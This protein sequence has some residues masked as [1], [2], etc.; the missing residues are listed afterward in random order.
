MNR[1]YLVIYFQF[2]IIYIYMNDMYN[3]Y[4]YV[5]VDVIKNK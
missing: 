2:K 5:F 3:K 4:N 1:K